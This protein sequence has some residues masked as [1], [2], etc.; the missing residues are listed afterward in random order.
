MLTHLVFIK[1]KDATDK[2]K[3]AVVEKLLTMNGK[4]PELRALEAGADIIGSERSYD[5][6][7]ITRFDSLADMEAYQV[8]P[9]HQTEILPYLRSVMSDAKAVDFES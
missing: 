4:I 1:L 5:V 2:N 9:Y 3:T 7:L 6:A 8:H